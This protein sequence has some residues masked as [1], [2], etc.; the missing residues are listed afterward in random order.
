MGMGCSRELQTSN[1]TVGPPTVHRWQPWVAP[2]TSKKIAFGSILDTR[3]DV[4]INRAPIVWEF[5][6]VFLEP[7]MREIEFNINLLLGTQTIYIPPY[8][9]ALAELRELTKGSSGQVERLAGATHFSKIDLRSGHHQLRVK[10][11][12]ISQTALRTRYMHFEF[13]N[14][15]V[16]ASASRQLKIH[17]K[18]Y[19]THDLKFAAIIFSLKIWHPYLYDH[20]LTILYHLGMEKVV[21]D[22]FS[23]KYMG[24]LA[25]IVAKR[26]KKVASVKV[27]WRNH[28]TEEAT[29]ESKGKRPMDPDLN[30]AEVT[31]KQASW[32]VMMTKAH[33]AA[34]EDNLPNMASLK[35][36]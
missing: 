3:E 13:S 31:S 30:I 27:F 19:L 1:K 26:S 36:A 16:V 18:N 24:S 8:R 5:A 4:T 15:K 28:P 9:I 14:G 32:A 6:D 35:W 22:A 7:P 20:D 29:W 17:E 2:E 33:L 11:E 25:C 12:D 23:R 10:T 21:V 34:R